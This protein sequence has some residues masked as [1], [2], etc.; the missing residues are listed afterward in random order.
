M[1]C[2]A[3]RKYVDKMTSIF[4]TPFRH[5]PSTEVHSPLEKGDH[6]ELDTSE[7]LDTEGIQKHKSLVSAMQWEVSIGRLDIN[8]AVITMS[9]FR[10]EPRKG[11][12]DRI[13]KIYCYLVKFKHATIR[14]R[15]E[16]PD[17]LGLPDHN[18]N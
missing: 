6:P 15:T 11:H 14:I 3:P 13:K 12:V 5:K 7:F 9:S 16:E 1:L 17:I 2:F 10:V 8:T 18:F 4:E